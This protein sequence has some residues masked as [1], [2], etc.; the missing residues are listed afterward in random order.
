MQLL[1]SSIGAPVEK[2]FWEKNDV[3]VC[4]VGVV[5]A[6]KSLKFFNF[7]EDFVLCIVGCPSVVISS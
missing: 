7:L 4:D 2:W 3:H 6:L 1:E 5:F